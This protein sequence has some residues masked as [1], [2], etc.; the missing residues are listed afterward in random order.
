[1]L[2]WIWGLLRRGLRFWGVYL[3]VTVGL[4]LM[5]VLS[6][7]GGGGRGGDV[8][9]WA[10]LG[11]WSRFGCFVAAAWLIIK[12]RQALDEHLVA[13]ERRL[14]RVSRAIPGRL[15]RFPEGCLL[16]T[17]AFF[18]WW[19]LCF[20]ALLLRWGAP[21]KLSA[22]LMLVSL[23]A[24]AFTTAWAICAGVALDGFSVWMHRLRARGVPLEEGEYQPPPAF[25]WLVGAWTA[26][27]LT[28]AFLGLPDPVFWTKVALA[29]GEPASSAPPSGARVEW[30]VELGAD[31]D[32]SEL[33]DSLV[34]FGASASPAFPDV[35]ASEDAELARTWLIEVA[36]EQALG[37][38]LTLAIA[39]SENIGEIELN[40]VISI[41]GWASVEAEEPALVEPLP[42]NDPYAGQQGALSQMGARGALALLDRVSGGPV[43]VAIVDTGVDGTLP[44]LRDVMW[45][46]P[47][48]GDRHGH[49]TACAAAAGAE[50]HNR[51]GIASLNLRGRWL[52]LLSISAL[53]GGTGDEHGVAQAIT[54]AAKA[55]A[56]VI[57]LSFGAEGVAPNVVQD[58]L[59]LARRKDVLVV[60]AAGN[61]G[62]TLLGAARQ[63]PANVPGVLVVGATDAY[64]RRAS[65][66]NAT[67]MMPKHVSAPG[68]GLLL[69]TPEGEHVRFAGTSF[70]APRVAGLA[71]VL[72]AL[73]PKKSA[74]E[75]IQLLID[76]GGP[77]PSGLGP[78]VQAD[79]AV[80]A[81]IRACEAP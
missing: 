55:G 39:E 42:V 21:D 41:G 69:P 3:V 53:P 72:R 80:E 54:Y 29:F 38:L 2:S 27:A 23:Q 12:E 20:V 33:R 47:V 19:G 61:E 11:A 31:D 52:E 63:W 81:A 59:R 35:S 18:A 75:V 15:S 24:F 6:A 44:D 32:I 10:L 40:G 13:L 1:M 46:K 36:E 79:A 62:D 57:S 56:R 30:L 60:A 51:T 65:W 26:G 7:D 8:D 22:L 14:H 68:E 67:W 66:S 34:P 9:A 25:P 4:P 37:L 77:A 45:P 17:L 76:T 64:G 48:R 58:A 5:A 70:A 16:R 49:G 28:I 50:A 78:A 73:C 43:R 71:G 74:D